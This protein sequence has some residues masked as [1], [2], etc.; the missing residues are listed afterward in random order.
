MTTHKL[1]TWPEYFNQIIE[2]NK[3]FEVR[4]NDRNFMIG[5]TLILQE[6]D[7]IV[8]LY[9]GREIIKTITYILNLTDFIGFF[10]TY[11]VISLK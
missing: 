11:I 6:F 3:N 10:T 7:P 8:K 1:K 2:G 4:R 5:D 9:T